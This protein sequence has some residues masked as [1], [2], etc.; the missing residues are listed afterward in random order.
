MN[1]SSCYVQYGCAWTAPESWRN[2]DASPT[3]R[4]ERL[5]LIGKLYVKNEK[6]F[7]S[8]VEY[9]DIT[10]GLPVNNNSCDA[11][12]CSHVL[13]H[14]SLKDCKIALI[15]TYKILK[16]GGVFR[17]VLPDLEYLIRIYI[18]KSR[19]G[20]GFPALEF[21]KASGLG[22]ESRN[23][24][25]KGVFLSAF[26]NSQHFWMWDFQSLARELEHA[27]FGGIRRAQFGDSSTKQFHE[28]ENKTRWEN[29]LGIECKRI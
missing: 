11:V 9:G 12:Y 7:P 23:R 26:G 20:V 27:G 22:L 6:R 28:V 25:I 4:F 10:K 18:E 13:E 24:G 14:L 2:F 21:M 29:C 1:L 19:A 16:P 15:N 17:L 8:N 5:P 3:L